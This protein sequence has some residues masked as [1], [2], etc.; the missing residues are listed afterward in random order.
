MEKHFNFQD[1]LNDDNSDRRR[2]EGSVRENVIFSQAAG[3]FL[4]GQ[5]WRNKHGKASPLAWFAL[6]GAR[7]KP[8]SGPSCKQP[9]TSKLWFYGGRGILPSGVSATRQGRRGGRET[10]CRGARPRADQTWPP[11][12]PGLPRAGPN[13]RQSRAWAARPP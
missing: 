8:E 7:G 13:N 10:R 2:T 3:R 1:T 9:L 6:R 12:P 4:V 11:T 5:P